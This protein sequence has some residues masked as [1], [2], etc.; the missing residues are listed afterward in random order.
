MLTPITVQSP[1]S[2][3]VAAPVTISIS[4]LVVSTK[5]SEPPSE[6]LV[7]TQ[8]AHCPTSSV[9]PEGSTVICPPNASSSVVAPSSTHPLEP[10]S[11]KSKSVPALSQ[12]SVV[13]AAAKLT[14]Q[15]LSAASGLLT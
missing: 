8:V 14:A 6:T 2:S 11:L 15:P 7:T 13:A 4:L 12:T 9:A 10:A 1:I 5:A 3:E